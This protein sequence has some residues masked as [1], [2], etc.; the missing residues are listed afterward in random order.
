MTLYKDTTLNLIKDMAEEV[1]LVGGAVRDY[2]MGQNTYDKDIIVTSISARDFAQRFVQKNDA[3]FIELDKENNIYRVVL[4]DKLN[5]IDITEP[6][7]NSLEEDLKRRDFTI[8]SIC[9]NLATDE[10]IDLC[11]G[12]KDLKNKII[13]SISEK[14]IVDDPLRMLRGFRFAATLGFE[15]EENTLSQIEKHIDLI[16]KPAIERINYEFLKLFSGNYTDRVLKTMGDNGIIEK[17]YPVFADVK[18]VPANSHHHLDLYNHSVEVVKQIQI[19]YDNSSEEI[20]SHLDKIAFGGFSRLTHLKLAGFFHDIGKF[21]TWTIEENGT[22]HRFIKHDD[23]GSKMATKIFRQNKFSKKQIEYISEIIRQHI[24]PSQVIASPNIN[25]KI[26]MRYI[27]KMGD[28][29]ID[30]ITLAKA[31]RLSARG[32]LITDDIVETNINNLNKLL[33][34]YLSIKDNLE[35]IPKLLTGTE[36]MKIKN[37]PESSELGDIIKA[38]KIEQ[39]DGNIKTKE[40]AISFV[41]QYK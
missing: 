24:Y 25:E 26:Y 7:N 41:I 33:N 39:L 40:E 31:D 6:I 36:I 35:P 32:P 23:V 8:N 13:R 20:K 16:N 22:R 10:I 17:M 21:S 12:Q 15:I 4:E 2:L 1:Y 30:N 29:I 19:I 14:N 5:F 27:R 28:N 38:L 18:K 37:I 9:I 34:Y 11:N 3:T